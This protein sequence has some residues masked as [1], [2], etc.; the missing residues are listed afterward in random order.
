[1]NAIYRCFGIILPR[2]T[3]SMAQTG[4]QIVSLE[5]MT[6]EEKLEKIQSMKP[7][8]AACN[9]KSCGYVYRT[10]K[11]RRLI[12]HNFTTCMGRG[13]WSGT[14]RGLPVSDYTAKSCNS[15]RHTIS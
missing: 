12:L 9:E 15:S 13:W 3:G 4:T 1:M 8:N 6:Q 10:R 11:W 5:G 7:G 2:N 14:K